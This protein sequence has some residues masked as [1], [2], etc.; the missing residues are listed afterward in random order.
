MI[1]FIEVDEI[2]LE[3]LAC[4]PTAPLLAA[5]FTDGSVRMWDLGTGAE[6]P[7]LRQEDWVVDAAFS[8]DGRLLAVLGES[9]TTRLWDLRT[10]Q[11]CAAAQTG[12]G[13]RVLFSPTGSQIAI[14][15]GQQGTFSVCT[16]VG[17]R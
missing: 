5:G 8:P 1:W 10:G 11:L 3:D 12:R 9:G 16:W 4:S 15:D 17:L 14:V 7:V 13:F 2:T 6:Q